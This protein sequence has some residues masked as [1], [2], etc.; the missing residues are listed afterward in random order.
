LGVFLISSELGYASGL[1]HLGTT[2][3]ISG[4]LQPL[5]ITGGIGFS[6]AC[7]MQS[8]WLVSIEFSFRHIRNEHGY[9]LDSKE[10]WQFFLAQGLLQGLCLSAMFSPSFARYRS[11]S[12]FSKLKILLTAVQ[13]SITGFLNVVVWRLAL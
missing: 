4:A 7:M 3:S 2:G 1:D 10:Y 5:I 8:I 13:A 6:F 12:P 11:L 9:L